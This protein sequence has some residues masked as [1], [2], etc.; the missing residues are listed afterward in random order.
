MQRIYF[1]RHGYTQPKEPHG[2]TAFGFQELEQVRGKLEVIGFRAT[3]AISSTELRAAQT[4]RFLSYDTEPICLEILHA[5]GSFE[6]VPVVMRGGRGGSRKNARAYTER[7]LNKVLQ[8]I[9]QDS[10]A[11]VSG[12]D[13]TPL[14]L[15]LRFAQMNGADILW[16]YLSDHRWFPNQG[17]GVLVSGKNLQYFFNKE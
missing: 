15:A 12:H 17:E 4:A 2:V 8:L 9:P 6:K 10:C 5:Y 13:F 14:M 7:A 1:T 11:V 16:D 3:V